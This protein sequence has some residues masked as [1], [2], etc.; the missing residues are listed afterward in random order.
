MEQKEMIDNDER[1]AKRVKKN[2]PFR[3]F[4]A[5]AAQKRLR[6]LS[7]EQV[8]WALRHNPVWALLNVVSE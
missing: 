6:S 3:S 1:R 4:R 7:D 2:R 8:V 5:N